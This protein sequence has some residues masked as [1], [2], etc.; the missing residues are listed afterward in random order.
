MVRYDTIFLIIV[1]FLLYFL[2]IDIYILFENVGYV[3]P[4]TQ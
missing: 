4:D 1:I 3:V 2:T